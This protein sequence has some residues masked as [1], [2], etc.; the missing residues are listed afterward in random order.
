VDG[1][2]GAVEWIES[3][4]IAMGA[5]VK[6]L[7]LTRGRQFET[8]AY[9]EACAH[10]V[11]S[12]G[13]IYLGAVTKSLM[14][15]DGVVTGAVVIAVDGT[16]HQ[17]RARSTLLA[18]GGFQADGELLG[19]L[20]HANAGEMQLRSNPWSD[21]AGLRLGRSAGG[22][23]TGEGARFYGHL[24]PTDVTL[25]D[26]SQFLSLAF[27]HSEHG[28]LFNISGHRFVDETV[29]DH[30]NAVATLEQPE[31]RALLVVDERV[32]RDWELA[33][34]VEGMPP[35]PDKF[36]AA[37]KRGARCATADSIDEFRHLPPEWG[38]DGVAIAL[39]IEAFN[40]SVV[41]SVDPPRRHDATPLVDPP[42][43]VVDVRPAVTFTYRGLAVDDRCQVLD[44]DD[45]P[46]PGLLAAGADVGG[47]VTREYAGGLA[48][49]CA[50]GIRAAQTAFGGP[51]E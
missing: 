7:P 51:S 16:E 31:A 24:V 42:Y 9:L 23:I 34:Y 30:V 33:P 3:L 48:T 36:A 26:P 37:Y 15:E 39:G 5:E 18:C 8:N 22:R 20:I 45:R 2:D 50:T 14:V 44:E 17:M 25:E 28:L 19:E 49:A 4:G 6:V 27:Y 1:Y 11:R 40:A 10:L 32:R 41:D 43:Y 12:H 38:Y 21:G 47:V 35:S 13:E 29:G 46:I